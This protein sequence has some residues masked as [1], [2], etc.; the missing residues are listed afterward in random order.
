MR[1]QDKRSSK[2]SYKVHCDMDPQATSTLNPQI[3]TRNPY[4]H[5]LCITMIISQVAHRKG[6]ALIS[7]TEVSE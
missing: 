4:S 5:M 7:R 2:T 1:K 6:A 3:P